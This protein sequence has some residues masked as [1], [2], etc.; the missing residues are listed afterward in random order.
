MVNNEMVSQHADEAAFLWATRDRA[1]GEPHYALKDLTALDERVEAHL[2]GLR[3]AAEVG[4]GFCKT[5]LLNDGPGEMFALAVLA[6]GDR[7]L[8]RMRD[9]LNAGCASPKSLPGLVSALAWLD[10]STVGEWIGRLL[11]AR[12]AQHRTVGIAACA[13]HREDPGA[14]L[15]RA[16]EDTDPVLRARALRA[17]GEI[18]RQ[19]LRELVRAHLEDDD[20]RCKF[21]AAWAITLLGARAGI[22]VLKRI[23]AS[24]SLLG[25]QALQLVLRAVELPE[26]R[27]CVSSLA[28]NPESVRLAILG[29]GVLGD[30]LSVPWL[31]KKMQS[32]EWARVAGEAFTTITGADLAYNDLNQDPP[33]PTSVD[34]GAG[35]DDIVP[36][37]YETN[38]PWPSATL[39]AKWWETNQHSFAIGTRY[40]GGRP[41]TVESA[42][43]LL[44]RGKQRLRVAAAVELALR[45]PDE[46]LFETRARGA[47]QE[48]RLAA[49]TS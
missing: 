26:G 28:R 40:L 47:W 15:T 21:W 6:F 1:I 5:N 49:W 10:Y 18:K 48:K 41:I 9:A 35:E 36:L 11:H 4:W 32:P 24:N 19:D 30:P 12:L 20:E 46:P 43:E 16:V 45:T 29:T 34:R 2:D 13:L 23:I 37:G 27:Q 22:P 44:E 38:L 42:I 39:V 7:K 17:A 3:V 25:D 14:A 31:I 8:D 33:A